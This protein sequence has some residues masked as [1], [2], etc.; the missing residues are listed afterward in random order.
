MLGEDKMN[1]VTVIRGAVLLP[2]DGTDKVIKGSDLWLEDARVLAI[3]P[4]GAAPPTSVTPSEILEV[5][6]RIV[7]P[8]LINSHS[9]SSTGLQRGT[10]FGAPLDLYVIHAMA[11]RAPRSMRQVY[12]SAMLEAMELL[13]N[14]VTTVIDHLRYTALPTPEAIDAACSAYNDVG[15]RAVVAP[16]FEDRPYIESL[17]I[18]PKRLPPEI[19]SRWKSA[20][21]P[22]PRDYFAILEEALG[23]WRGVDDRIDLMIGVDGPQRCTETLLGMT[24]DFAQRHAIGFHTH[25]LESKTQA[26]MAERD[27]GGS[28]VRHL[29]RFGLVGPQTSLVHFIWC[30]DADIEIAASRDAALVHNPLSNLQLGSGLQ[31]TARLLRAGLTIGLGTDGSSGYAASIFEQAK[32]ASLLSRISDV[33]CTNWISAPQAL[34]MATNHG[35]RLLGQADTLGIIAPGARADLTIID[36]SKRQHQPF[37]DI[38]N[39]MLT[40]EGGAG[41]EMVFVN[42][43][44]VVRNG[45]STRVD[46]VA[47][48]EEA[49]ELAKADTSANAEYVALAEFE[50]PALQALITE[51]LQSKTSVRRH[52]QL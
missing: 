43:S 37:G 34:S 10:I 7:L 42:G 39:H 31:P 14:G 35:A 25:L 38:W 2:M 4:S 40:Y 47:V 30:S 16:M 11:R 32:L 9:H 13:R 1:R 45:S 20:T 17:P 33:D 24:A 15:I 27:Y 19:A 29:D 36:L 49:V 23:R 18:D 46:E 44:I 51:A 22:D 5:P 48:L 52:A 3:V 26:L 41:V 28:L 12:I 6:G 8:G 21:T 50:R